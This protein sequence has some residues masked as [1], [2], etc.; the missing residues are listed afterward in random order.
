MTMP[1][2][3]AGTQNT[4]QS[5]NEKQH[6]A[7]LHRQTVIVCEAM[8]IVFHSNFAAYIVCQS[9]K[10]CEF[11][12]FV[13][14]DCWDNKSYYVITSPAN[15]VCPAGSHSFE[16]EH[17]NISSRFDTRIRYESDAVIRLRNHA[18]T[19]RGCW[20]QTLDVNKPGVRYQ[21]TA[22][23]F[24]C[25]HFFFSFSDYSKAIRKGEIS[26]KSNHVI[27]INFEAAN[28]R[29][30]GTTACPIL[31]ATYFWQVLAQ[32]RKNIPL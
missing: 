12:G 9:Y 22:Y 31:L 21:R 27:E 17:E 14:T 6:M 23:F 18:Y 28:G 25:S 3:S 24:C 26:F 29:I 8:Y 10:P 5:L 19:T 30:T 16:L 4:R 2:N 32:S 13:W 1:A 7:W 20:F 15:W 11:P